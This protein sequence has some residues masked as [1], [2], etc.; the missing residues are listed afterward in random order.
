[1]Y[2]SEFCICTS[3]IVK[4]YFSLAAVKYSKVRNVSYPSSVVFSHI[5]EL[6]MVL[7]LTLACF[8]IY[9]SHQAF[10]YDNKLW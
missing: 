7:F 9:G 6:C 3:H 8:N 4:L 10:H 2:R 1:M 5:L